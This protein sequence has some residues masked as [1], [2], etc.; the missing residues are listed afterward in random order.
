MLPEKS[1]PKA[2]LRTV[3]VGGRRSEG[4]RLFLRKMGSVGIGGGEE[5]VIMPIASVVDLIDLFVAMIDEV[6]GA[7]LLEGC[8]VGHERPWAHVSEEVLTDAD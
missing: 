3:I 1:R 2:G 4:G 8:L 7:K 6:R 5:L